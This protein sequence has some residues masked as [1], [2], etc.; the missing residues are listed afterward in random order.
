MK[1]KGVQVIALTPHLIVKTLS[2]SFVFNGKTSST[3]C[4]VSISIYVGRT[5]R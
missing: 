1:M 4:K 5:K 3:P 2:D